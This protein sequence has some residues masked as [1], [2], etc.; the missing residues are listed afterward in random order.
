MRYLK[1]SNSEREKVEIQRRRKWKSDYQGLG[2]GESGELFI[3]HKVSVWK[4][5]KDG[6]SDG[7]MMM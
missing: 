7:Y 5:K 6:W 1:R 3:K 4:D 2:R